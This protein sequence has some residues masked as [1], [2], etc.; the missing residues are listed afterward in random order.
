MENPDDTRNLQG[1]VPANPIPTQPPEEKEPVAEIPGE[2]E[3]A[4][5]GEV[6]ELLLAKDFLT[7]LIPKD[8]RSMVLYLREKRRKRASRELNARLASPK[9][10]KK[11]A[12]EKTDAAPQPIR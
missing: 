11:L 8:V 9:K 4:P 3:L 1:T 12:K 5:S 10:R 6:L 7:A 2:I